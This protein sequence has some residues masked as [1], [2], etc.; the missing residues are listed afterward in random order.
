MPVAVTTRAYDNTRSGANMQETVLTPQAVAAKGII[1]RFSLPLQGDKRGAEAQPLVV[2]QVALADGTSKDVIFVATMANHVYA[3]DAAANGR[4]LWQRTLG[5]PVNGG[6]T[7]DNWLVNDHW[8]ILSTPVIDLSTG[9]LYVV[10]W[11][12]PDGSV[13]RA[14]HFIHALSIRD[15]RDVHP[16]VNLE[17]AS[18][19]PGHGLPVQQFRSAERKQRASLLLTSV[20]GV[21]TIF[22]GFGTIAEGSQTARGWII[23]CGTEPF[24][25]T[26]AW[27]STAKG[28]GG[29]I[30]QAG[31]GLVADEQGFIYAMTGNGD[32][33]GVTD[34]GE[35]FVKLAY[36]N[37]R[38]GAH[39]SLKVVD[40]W[41]PWTDTERTHGAPAVTS[42]EVL[43][44]NFRAH[45]AGMASD[46]GD[47]DLGSGGPVLVSS[48]GALVGAGKD[49]ILYV[50]DAQRM[51]KTAPA[52]LENPAGNYAKLKSPP[53]FFSYFPGFGTNP[54]PPN[55]Q[56]LNILFANR[57]HHQHGSPVHWESPDLGPLLYCWGEN[58]NLRAWSI[59]ADGTV[60][61][62]AT[63]VE[64]ASAQ[65]P[66][67][68]GGMPGGMLTLSAN[69]ATKHSGI[70]WATIPY[71]DANRAVGSGRL[72]AYDATEF[73]T[74]ADGSKQ[75][76]VLWDSQAENLPFVY[77][78][79][80]PPVVA[81][82]MVLVA[83]YD[84]K[85]DV[86]GL[87]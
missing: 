54:A 31:A 42:R 53:I 77:N 26:A 15:G 14:Q 38:Q 22:V 84:G 81:N 39:A 29:G 43:P 41:T 25:I 44:T 73:G 87:V 57:T 37:P 8:G 64:V 3:F 23:A 74:F 46:W 19:D 59:A 48:A 12:S 58:G 61:Y 17:A 11:V 33:D 82:G 34:F 75:L 62:L 6:K 27:T 63:G 36:T 18:C 40:W 52:D 55:I 30:W 76:R 5:T 56:S 51:G 72:I 4:Q 66:V 7:I 71:F 28:Q 85:I 65:S 35:S 10:A 86:Y 80:N 9:T 1:R 49:G 13:A 16:A 60:R 2:P 20:G 68:P 70:V 69:G 45:A 67:P 78:K 50:L 21:S 32:F 83:T 24:E 79:F 47:Q